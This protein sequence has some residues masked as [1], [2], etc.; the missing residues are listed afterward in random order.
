MWRN[1][2]RYPHILPQ[3]KYQLNILP[4]FRDEFWKWFPNQ[5]IQLQRDFHHLNSSQALC[6]NLFYPMLRDNGQGLAALSSAMGIADLPKT[7]AAFEFQPDPDEGTCIDFSLPLQ[8]ATRVNFE[9]KYTETEF[10]SAKADKAHLEKF[11]RTYKSRLAGRFKESFYCAERFLKHYQIAR[12]VWHLNEAAR[13]IAVFL[14]PSANTCLRQEL[15]AR[16]RA[17]ILFMAGVFTFGEAHTA[18]VCATRRRYYE[19]SLTDDLL[20]TGLHNLVNCI[21]SRHAL[22][23]TTPSVFTLYASRLQKELANIGVHVP[24][25]V[26]KCSERIKTMNKVQ[27]I[28]S[29]TYKH[30]LGRNSVLIGI[31]GGICTDLVTMAASLV[32]RG[33]G[34]IRI[35]TTL[36]T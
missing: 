3:Q 26:L 7:G 14:F 36:S 24:V 28:C 8:S 6:F 33:I 9:I 11:E 29:E 12:N 5:R 1:G 16:W 23:V 4:S 19:V 20:Q 34:Y 17:H 35:P 18:L 22:I 10:G 32:R 13:D 2:Q 21:G 27:Y 30:G 31:G 15:P 25:I